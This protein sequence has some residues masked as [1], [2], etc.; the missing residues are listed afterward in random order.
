VTEHSPK[1]TVLINRRKVIVDAFT[2][3]LVGLYLPTD[4]LGNLTCPTKAFRIEC[5]KPNPQIS[6]RKCLHD[7]FCNNKSGLAFS[8]LRTEG[9]EEYGLLPMSVAFGSLKTLNNWLYTLERKPQE[10]LH[11]FEA[12]YSN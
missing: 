7:I 8:L 1:P 9:E 3:P 6:A 5:W 12:Y 11:R 2:N 10:D 4:S